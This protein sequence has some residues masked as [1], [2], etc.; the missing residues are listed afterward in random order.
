MSYTNAV[1]LGSSHQEWL[2]SLD[3]YK[4]EIGFLEKRLTEVTTKN[5]HL[6]A[7]AGAEHFQNQFIIQRNNIDEL[8]HVING[9]THEVFEDVS[10]H[11]GRVEE[12]KMADHEK[13]GQDVNQLEKVINELRQEFNKYVAKWI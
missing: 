1:N 5:T 10:K 12:G 9:H 7:K 13:I 8:K 6:D 4:D 11:V 3:F 2:K